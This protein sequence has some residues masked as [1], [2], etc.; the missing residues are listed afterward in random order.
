ME[1]KS[2]EPIAL[3]SEAT[4]L[5]KQYHAGRQRKDELTKQLD[6]V[7]AE[8]DMIGEDL[9]K[10]MEELGLQ[11]FKLEGLGTYYL[12]TS[13]YPKVL[14]AEKVIDWLDKNGQSNIAPRTIKGPAFKEF[15]QERVEHDQPIPPPDLVEASSNTGVRLRRAKS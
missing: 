11:T 7:K 2:E 1:M 12:Q 3:T 8:L 15:Y 10:K 9:T 5:A 14:D 6:D 13:F 4:Q